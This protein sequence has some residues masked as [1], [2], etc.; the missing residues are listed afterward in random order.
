MNIKVERYSQMETFDGKTTTEIEEKWKY[1]WKSPD[2]DKMSNY[3]LHQIYSILMLLLKLI[4][5]FLKESMT[6]MF[7]EKR[8]KIKTKTNER[9]SAKIIYLTNNWKI[10]SS[11]LTKGFTIHRYG[12]D[13][14][15][16]VSVKRYEEFSWWHH[17]IATENI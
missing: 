1:K 7:C 8:N 12:G 4:R 2:I 3:W 14:W 16:N 10:L 5:E 9:K 11:I 6:E 13:I 15:K 17:E